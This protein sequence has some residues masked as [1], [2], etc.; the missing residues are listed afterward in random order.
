MG[1]AHA[2]WLRDF[3][4]HHPAWDNPNNEDIFSGDTICKA[5]MLIEAVTEAGLISA[6]PHRMP[7]H[8]HHVTKHWSRLDQVF[9]LEHSKNMLMACEALT[10]HRGINTDHLLIHTELSLDIALYKPEPAPNFREVDCEEFRKVLDKHLLPTQLDEPISNQVLLD[11]CC[12]ELT[13]ALQKAICIAVPILSP[14]PNYKCWWTKELMQLQKLANK[15]GRKSYG[16][17]NLPEH[18]IHAEHR[19]AKRLYDSTLHFA[20]RQH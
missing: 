6:L 5:E 13:R 20:K 7:T 10:G 12:S 3:N 11:Q 9:I 8:C 15:L 16:L 1:A 4:R 19:E 14:A 18:N 2:I 17:W